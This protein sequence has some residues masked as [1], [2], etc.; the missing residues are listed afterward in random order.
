MEVREKLIV[1]KKYRVYAQV[2]NRMFDTPDTIT[3]L[4]LGHAG[5]KNWHV[6]DV[7]GH[8]FFRE[9][10]KGDLELYR[11]ENNII[12]FM[13]DAGDEGAG[14][15]VGIDVEKIDLRIPNQKILSSEEK[16]YLRRMWENKQE[17]KVA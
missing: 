12:S 17:L 11:S 10:P 2:R 7:A 6:N 1:G 4:Y 3:C 13:C 16:Q 15:S 5:D 9:N 14:Y 8:L